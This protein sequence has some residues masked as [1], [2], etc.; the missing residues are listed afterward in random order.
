M[1]EFKCDAFLS[2]EDADGCVGGGN[3]SKTVVPL[4]VPIFVPAPMA[5]FSMPTPV[6]VPLPLPIPVPCF[7]PT[8]RNSIAAIMKQLQVGSRTSLG[9][10]PSL[11]HMYNGHV[12]IHLAGL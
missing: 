4:P 9:V 11:I 6:P 1:S 3:G 8:T 5:M 7:V 12:C 2:D 10:P